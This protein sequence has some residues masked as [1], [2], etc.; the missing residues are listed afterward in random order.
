MRCWDHRPP[1]STHH[2]SFTAPNAIP[3]AAS[4]KV[5]RSGFVQPCD[6]ANAPGSSR[7]LLGQ[8]TRRS[9]RVADLEVVRPTH[10]ASS[11][12]IKTGL[13]SLWRLFVIAAVTLSAI[14]VALSFTPILRPTNCGGNSSALYRVNRLI[15]FAHS[16]SMGR[17]DGAFNFSK[18]S[19][20]ES[21]DLAQLADSGWNRSAKFYVASGDI[22]F[23]AT[24]RRIIAVCN[25]PYRN[26]P[27]RRLG[28]WLWPAPPTHAVA[29]SDG[30]T[31]LISPTEYASINQSD[32]LDL[33]S[34][35]TQRPTT[36]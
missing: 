31:E 33:A 12:S 17:P 24:T 13:K 32:L 28:M 1:L 21:R 11:M 26:V 10:F 20:T 14:V 19:K 16:A 18:L 2:S 27:E 8:E 6:A 29:F 22:S 30:T 3:N 36:E 23:S 4:T 9:L 35:V 5:P 25:T 15:R 7:L 34:I